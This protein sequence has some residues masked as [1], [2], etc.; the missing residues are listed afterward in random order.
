VVTFDDDGA[1][2]PNPRIPAGIG[3]YTLPSTGTYTIEV[4]SYTVPAVGAYTLKLMAPVTLTISPAAGVVTGCRPAEGKIVLGKPAPAGGLTL[5]ISDTLAA[6][7]P[8]S[9]VTI[10]AGTLTKSFTIP[11]TPVLSTQ[12]GTVTARF[13]GTGGVSSSDSLSIRPISVDTLTLT[14]NPV[15]GPNSSIG[16][17]ALECNA[18]PQ[19]ITVTLG[20]SN[21]PVAWPAVSTVTIPVGTKNRS[22][23]VRTADVSTTRNV[24]IRATA[25]G[26]NKTKTL[27][28]Q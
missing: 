25:N 5:S 6:A 22:F 17:I 26:R 27:T 18:G 19:A 2:Y 20:T 24:T 7:S 13:G 15:V 4:T 9:T 1:G 28:V 12:S 3:Y 10:P 16:T 11:T 8:P 21:A 23:T 14:P